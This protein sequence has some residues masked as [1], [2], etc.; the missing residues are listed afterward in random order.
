MAKKPRK[1]SA[2][3]V[4]R[5]PRSQVIAERGIKT[6]LDFADLMSALMSDVI[7]G[8]VTPGI[9]N[10]TC[11]AGGKLLRIVELRQKYGTKKGGE[12]SELLLARA[13]PLLPK[14]K[15]VADA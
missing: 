9:A 15:P 2:S 8:T 13:I 11:N 6:D 10:A 4:V 12:N 5:P 3:L 14:S 7:A 1:S